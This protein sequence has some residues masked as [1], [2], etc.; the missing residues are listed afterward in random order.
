PMECP[1]HCGRV[2][3]TQKALNMHLSQAKSCKWYRQFEKTAALDT[4]L[5]T[6]MEENT[7]MVREEEPLLPAET[8]DLL[9][10]LEEEND[11]FHFLGAKLRTFDDVEEGERVVEEN[12]EAGVIIRMDTSLRARWLLAH[13][14]D[15]DHPMDGSPLLPDQAF[16]PFA[17]EMDWRIAE[18]VVKDGI[19]HKSLDRLLAIPGVKD[20]LGLSYTNIAGL[21]KKIDNLRP[22]AGEWKVRKL[23]F[24][25]EED[26][27]FTLRHRDIL[28]CIQSLWGDPALADHLVY[29][30]K[31]I[32]QD[33]ERKKRVYSEMWEGKWWQ[34]TQVCIY[35]YMLDGLSDLEITRN[36]SLKGQRWLL[37]SLPQTRHS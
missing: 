3:D 10:E 16:A 19:G 12:T 26:Y 24:K 30:P 27:E 9:Q 25:D 37:S 14:A 4:V 15:V 36:A 23:R 2:F 32:F 31:K 8:A 1:T 18:W 29:R 20:K 34:F 28:E 6:E 35:S 13:N 22:R 5:Q 33:E 21:H 7:S 11:L 17:S